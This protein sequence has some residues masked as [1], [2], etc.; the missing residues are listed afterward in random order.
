[1]PKTTPEQA[2][3]IDGALKQAQVLQTRG[4][5]LSSTLAERRRA[6]YAERLLHR[7]PSVIDPFFWIDVARAMP[8]EAGRL[9]GQTQTLTL[10]VEERFTNFDQPAAYAAATALALIAVV[11]LLI[12]R[13]LRPEDGDA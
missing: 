2:R 9:V 3:E 4:E 7:T 13:L 6:A 12:T 1:M 10:F 8:D 5:Q 11:S